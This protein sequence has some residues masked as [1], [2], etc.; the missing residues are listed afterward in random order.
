MKEK[1]IVIGL[2]FG[3]CVGALPPRAAAQQLG[4]PTILVLDE[5]NGVNYNED[6]ADVTKFATSSAIVPVS[7]MPSWT[8]GTGFLDIYAING[9]TVKGLHSYR[10]TKFGLSTATLTPGAA[11]SD[12]AR[13]SMIQHVWEIQDAN[14][15][16][17]P[18]GIHIR[19]FN[20]GSWYHKSFSHAHRWVE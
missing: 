15:V 6:T 14:G 3:L 11:I 19:P 9:Q 13:L 12:V 4:T 1:T 17:I 5:R 7:L 18:C 16:A 8:N 10:F 2:V 20:K